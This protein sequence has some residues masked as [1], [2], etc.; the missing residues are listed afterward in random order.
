MPIPSPNLDDRSFEQL[1]EDAKSLVERSDC[2]WTDLSA[3]DPGAVLLEAFAYLTSLLIYR[4]NRLPEKVYVELLRLIGVKLAPPAAAAVLLRFSRA[5]PQPDAVW[6]PAGTRVTIARSGAGEAPIFTTAVAAQIL[7]GEDSVAGVLAHH[8]TLV[9]AEFIGTGTGLARQTLRILQPPII[10]STG[11]D[12]DAVIAVEATPAELGERVPALSHDGRT[13]RIWR[14]VENF[15][16]SATDDHVYMLDRVNGVVSFAPALRAMGDDGKLAKSAALVAQVPAAGRRILAF[17]RRGGGEDGNLA[18]NTLVVLRDPINGVQVTNPEPATGASA[19]ETV[20]NALLRGPEDMHSLRRAVTARDFE[21]VAVRSSASVAR[22]R[23]FTKAEL[24]RHAKLGTVEVLLVPRLGNVDTRGGNRITNDSL[25]AVETD[26]VRDII[27]ATLEERRALGTACLVNWVRYKTVKVMARVVVHRGED[28]DAVRARVL[29]RLSL[30]INP[31]PTPLQRNGWCF[32][33]PLRAS[34]VYDIVLAEPGVSYVD[35]VR[36][37]VDQ[38]PDSNVQALAIDPFQPATWYASSAGI[39]YRSLNDGDGWEPAGQFDGETIDGICTS[40]DIAGLIGV[41]TTLAGGTSRV[42]MSRDCG[43]SWQQVA[44]LGFVIN[45]IAWLERGD[46]QVLLMATD[47][48][49]Y[50]LALQDGSSPLQVMV[51]KDNASQG[52]YAV[53]AFTDG[54]GGSNVAL[55]ARQEAGIFMSRDGGRATSFVRISAPGD[56]IRV[57]AV[58]RLGLGTFL[59]AGVTSVGNDAGKGCLRWELPATPRSVDSP[60]GWRPMSTNWK[61][62]SCRAIAFDGLNVYAAT[63]FAGVATLDSSRPDVGW[64]VSGIQSGLPMRGSEKLFAPVQTIA[65]A[66]GARLVMAGGAQGVFRSVGGAEV[67]TYASSIEFSEKV[68]LPPT[69]LFCSGEHDISVVTTD[70]ANRH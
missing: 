16:D 23:A 49:L 15:S 1:L 65:V 29:D 43:E 50:E 46:I 14:R 13:Y 28:T 61:G 7:P 5:K 22:A 35:Q 57:L 4:M 30:T 45:D 67:F 27:L 69:W 42:H 19:C 21:A 53:A 18:A 40:P 52:F 60:E 34:H 37:R 36:F 17:Y 10:A 41:S 31:L 66:E 33:E 9:E 63:Y 55:A 44:D 2:G 59:W 48:G 47:K 8:C 32:G 62:G 64:D 58:Q 12:F 3:G 68:A 26:S 38:V 11:D 6:I 39:L 25:R 70:E 51:D 56:D 20:D 54:R 24:W